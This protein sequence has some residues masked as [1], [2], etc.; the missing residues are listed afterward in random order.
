MKQLELGFKQISISKNKTKR[1]HFPA[2]LES[3]NQKM[4]GETNNDRK[5]KFH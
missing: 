4:P 3:I 1:K 2:N 5:E